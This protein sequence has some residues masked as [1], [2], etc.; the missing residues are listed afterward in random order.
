MAVDLRVVAVS[1][2]LVVFADGGWAAPESIAATGMEPPD[3]AA[4][5]ATNRYCPGDLLNNEAEFKACVFNLITAAVLQAKKEPAPGA[6]VAIVR[7]GKP[8]FTHGFGC[9][10]VGK[11][12]LVDDHTMFRA[13]SISKI[14]TATAV[15]QLADHGQ[16]GPGDLRKD[17]LPKPIDQYF[18]EPTL[19][20]VAPRSPI[21]LLNLLTHTAGV[22]DNQIGYVTRGPDNTG[23]SE[24][25]RAHRPSSFRS[26]TTE[27]DPAR[28]PRI[29][30]EPSYS[31][32][33]VELLGQLVVD[34]SADQ[35]FDGYVKKEILDPLGMS[36]SSFADSDPA[37]MAKVATGH[38]YQENPT[39]QN[40]SPRRVAA[41]GSECDPGL[42][43]KFVAR[44]PEYL[45]TMAP[46]A[47]FMTTGADMSRFMSAQLCVDGS[48]ALMSC[49]ALQLMQSRILVPNAY[50]GFNAAGL[51]WYEMNR[52]GRRVVTHS[53]KTMWSAAK[54]V[55]LP[56]EKLGIFIA[57]N[58]LM[59]DTPLRN[60]IVAF[61]DAYDRYLPSKRYFPA[62]PES[63]DDTPV[64]RYAGTYLPNP[65]SYAKNEKVTLVTYPALAMQVRAQSDGSLRISHLFGP[66]SSW[67]PVDKHVFRYRA[68]DGRP[69]QD[70]I[71]FLA[72]ERGE[73]DQLLT[74]VP[75]GPAYKVSGYD[76]PQFHRR[77][78]KAAVLVFLSAML[79][80][81]MK[82][83]TRTGQEDWARWCLVAMALVNLIAGY[84][85]KKF[86]SDWSVFLLGYDA[87]SF[88]GLGLLMLSIP[89][90][91][92]VIYFSIV[93]WKNG[94]WTRP[95]R[96]WYTTVAIFGVAILCSA[97]YWNLIGYQMS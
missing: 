11:G 89:L 3:T 82:K 39:P 57:A 13:G 14:V 1:A 90:T 60:F 12:T 83:S 54:L 2:L 75:Y 34:H 61:L 73:I 46:A 93:A 7:P 5:G 56:D 68:S 55:L 47:G 69:G 76:N 26:A 24:R 27:F 77:L 37:I 18:S 22:E 74:P 33:G 45:H 10:D 17:V 20:P 88:V 67:V 19:M 43:S 32:W 85:L 79:W 30:A 44:G 15:M 36:E 8:A 95:R 66:D 48:S 9:A 4:S 78:V 52:N 65:H 84:L 92:G 31:S 58:A 53:G 38:V 91:L 41:V 49:D 94:F 40:S 71:A 51:A 16:L 62:P 63:N 96:V 86:F 25:L 29:G 28:N 81:V 70:L 72:N 59:S 35:S 21:S 23:V 80:I 87:D 6:V 97:W 42:A 50:P 64:E